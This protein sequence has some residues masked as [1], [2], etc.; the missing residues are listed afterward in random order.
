M[1]S[2]TERFGE[3]ATRHGG[4]YD[5]GSADQW[6]RRP[7]SPHF[8]EGGSMMS[9]KVTNLTKEQIAAYNAGFDEQEDHKDWG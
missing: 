9:P 8:Y 1:K 6:Y 4:P 3:E 5:R 7:R 2:A